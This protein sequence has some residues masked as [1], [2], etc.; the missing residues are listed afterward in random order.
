[1]TRTTEKLPP[2]EVQNR[3]SLLFKLHQ[4]VCLPEESAPQPIKDFRTVSPGFA[5]D[6]QAKAAKSLDRPSLSPRRKALF[7]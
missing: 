1:M 5:R 4:Q 7:F 2:S 3:R 6:F